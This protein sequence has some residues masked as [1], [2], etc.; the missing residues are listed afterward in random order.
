MNFKFFC[1]AVMTFAS[2]LA[3]AF[4]IQTQTEYSPNL[5]AAQACNTTY[6]ELIFCRVTAWGQLP[7]GQ[8]GYAWADFPLT[9]GQCEWA[10]VNY[11]PYEQYCGPQGFING[12]ATADCRF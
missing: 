9:P 5:V 12:N 1:V 4:P 3:L 7:T 8:W 10:Y 11:A 6:N 2:S